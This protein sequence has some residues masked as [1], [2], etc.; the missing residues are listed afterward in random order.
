MSGLPLSS[1]N[2]DLHSANEASPQ[3]TESGLAAAEH[4]PTIGEWDNKQYP[5]GHLSLDPVSFRACL[6]Q[7]YEDWLGRSGRNADVHLLQLV[8]RRIDLHDLF[9]DV[10]R[11]RVRA[12]SREVRVEYIAADV[13][14]AA[15]AMSVVSVSADV[16]RRHTATKGGVARSRDA[17]V[18]KTRFVSMDER[19]AYDA[20][21]GNLLKRNRELNE[22]L[23]TC[24][25]KKIISMTRFWDAVRA[26]EQ[27]EA[28]HGRTAVYILNGG[29]KRNYR[30]LA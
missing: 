6:F 11:T 9:V 22:I 20:A 12:A 13:A 7:M 23:P 21:L 30:K 5:L 2:F 17:V 25:T 4:T 1:G 18:P 28:L 14:F 26:L 15:A 24:H 27:P 3:S 29:G 19:P 16:V 10:N 8:D